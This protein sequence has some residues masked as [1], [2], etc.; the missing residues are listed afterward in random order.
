MDCRITQFCTISILLFQCFVPNPCV[1]AG[2]VDLLDDELYLKVQNNM[3]IQDPLESLNRIVFVFNDTAY[4]YMLNPLATGY[5]NLISKDLRNCIWNFFR[6]LEEPARFVNCIL[7]GRFKESWWVLSRFI[8]NSICGVFGL[9][10]PAT[11]DFGIPLINASLGETM[12]VWGIGDGFYIVIPFYGSTTLRD[13]TGTFLDSMTLTPYYSWAYDY[14]N[15][16]IIYGVKEINK[17]S[18]FLTAYDDMKR[19]SLDPY[20]AYRDVY[21]QN[22]VRIRDH[23]N[24]H[25]HL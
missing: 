10:N 4:V 22:L 21:F 8:I 2:E 1:G 7:Q 16:E 6:N 3:T 9:G 20:A 14:S 13:F 18:F 5:S 25:L 19:I 24:F 11:V 12:A 15:L 17:I 23:E